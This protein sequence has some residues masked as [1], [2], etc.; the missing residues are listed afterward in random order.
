MMDKPKPSRITERDIEALIRA[1]NKGTLGA[2]IASKDVSWLTAVGEGIHRVDITPLCDLALLGLKS[3]KYETWIEKEAREGFRDSVFSQCNI[4]DLV[5]VLV[6]SDDAYT[7]DEWHR[8][9]VVSVANPLPSLSRD[10]VMVQILSN[11]KI[12]QA[13]YNFIQRPKYDRY[14]DG[15]NNT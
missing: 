3:Q 9:V 12:V 15:T 5:E 8:A 11:N 13:Q 10:E 14:I 7:D 1:N 4:G 6:S 2:T